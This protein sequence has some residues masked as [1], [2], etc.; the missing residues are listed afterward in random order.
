MRV[1]GVPWKRDSAGLGSKVSIWL[2]APNM[3][4]KMQ[5]LA[6]PGRWG[7]LGARGLPVVLE[8]AS[9]PSWQSMDESATDPNPLPSR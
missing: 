1:T 3:K 8:A 2:G 4:R 7:G 9:R 6:L 5:D